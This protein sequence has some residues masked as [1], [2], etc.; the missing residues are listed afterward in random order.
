MLNLILKDYKNPKIHLYKIDTPRITVPTIE[1]NI[2]TINI[3]KH[4]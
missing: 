2:P 3:F 1:P 4:I